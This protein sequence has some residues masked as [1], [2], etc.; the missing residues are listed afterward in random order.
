MQT[1]YLMSK[2]N[3]ILVLCT[4]ALVGGSVGYASPE[5][6]PNIENKMDAAID[7][8][9]LLQEYID[10]NGAV[11]AAVGLI[12]QGKI[13]FFTYGKKSIQNNELVSKDTI[14]EI[15]SITKVFTTLALMDMVTNGEVKLDEPIQTYLPSVKVPEWEGEK[16]TLRHLATHHSGL[17]SLPENFNPQNQLNPYADYTPEE[18][19]QF[20]NNYTLKRIPGEEFEYSNV[21]MGLL[22]AILSKEAGKSYE[23]LIRSRICNKLG[24]KNTAITLSDDMKKNFASGYHLKQEMEHWD[25]PTLA[26]A[27]AM[28]SNVKDMTH[29]MSAS[30][31]LLSSPIT[32]LLRGCHKSQGS[33]GTPNVNI[34]LGWIIS[35]SD[36]ADVIWHNGG[37]GG[38]RSFLGFNLKT[39]KGIVVLSNSTEGWPDLFGLSLLDPENY[40][41]PVVDVAL[42]Q[43]LDY[44]KRFEGLYEVTTS[45][46]QK[47]EVT[48][49]LSDSKL[50]YT[51]QGGEVQLIPES[52]SIFGL[53]GLPGQKLHFSFDGSGNVIKAELLVLPD[54]AIVAEMVRKP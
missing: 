52:F 40:K 26:G 51:A 14:F 32:D 44:L 36:N 23:E 3:S 29:F 17:P 20:L 42:K 19:Y 6:R 38:F 37:T 39:Q 7:V 45:D 48:L 13:Q 53:R 18:L 22:G 21:G 24:M 30:M 41:K 15:G 46:Q 11:G 49:K 47:F 4:L 34:G 35:S 1:G 50:I 43:D 25:V 27:G 16:I 28:R 10:D 12:D 33:A 5:S 2:M 9:A 54:N 31:G 8:Q